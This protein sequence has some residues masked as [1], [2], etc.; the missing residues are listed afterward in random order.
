MKALVKIKVPAVTDKLKDAVREAEELVKDTE[1]YSEESL[2]T[3]R[4]AIH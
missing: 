4:D 2:K 3:L 1:K